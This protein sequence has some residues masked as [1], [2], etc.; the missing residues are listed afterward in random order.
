MR[1]SDRV[2]APQGASTTIAASDLLFASG[3]NSPLARLPHTLEEV[4]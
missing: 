2:M 3:A 1:G 4:L